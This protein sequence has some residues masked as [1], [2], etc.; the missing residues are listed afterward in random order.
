MYGR[1]K[2]L[3]QHIDNNDYNKIVGHQKYTNL[4]S[5][6]IIYPIGNQMYAIQQIQIQSISLST[7]TVILIT[8]PY[9]GTEINLINTR[10]LL[11]IYIHLQGICIIVTEKK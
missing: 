4:T 3:K 1:M 7:Q 11:T 8:C 6:Q 9:V 5:Y 10:R 2:I